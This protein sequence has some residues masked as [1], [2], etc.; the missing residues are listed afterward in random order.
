MTPRWSVLVVLHDSAAWIEAAIVSLASQG[1]SEMELLVLDNAS[2]DDGLRRAVTV[3]RSA[4]LQMRSWRSDRNLGFAGG[5]ARLRDEARGEFLLLVNPDVRLATGFLSAM[6]RVFAEVPRAGAVGALL[7]DGAGRII[8][9]G[10]RIGVTGLAEHLGFG[11]PIKGWFSVRRDVEYATG[12]A[13]GL[14]RA[15]IEAVGFLDPGFFPAYFEEADLCAR[16]RCDGWKVIVEPAARASHLGET[17]RGNENPDYLYRYHRNRLRYARRNFSA[18]RLALLPFIEAA[19]LARQ[20]IRRT[21]RPV[22]AA[23]LAA[24]GLRQERGDDRSAAR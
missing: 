3:A 16:L 2:K 24:A 17:A 12:A 18:L 10:G 14:R 19:W 1:V 23:W 9:A 6:E 5:M 21:I 4:G 8:H 7:D 11:A 13:L 15:A 20:S 22:V